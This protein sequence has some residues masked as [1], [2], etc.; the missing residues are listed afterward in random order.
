VGTPAARNVGAARLGFSCSP[1]RFRLEALPSQDWQDTMPE[2][3][4]RA[5]PPTLTDR[6]L[7]Q[8]H[9]ARRPIGRRPRRGR[10]SAALARTPEQ[11]QEARSLRRVFL[12]LGDAYRQYRRRTEA[13]VSA[14]VRDAAT[15]FRKEPSVTSLVSVAAHLD[16]LKILTW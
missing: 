10:S 4:P 6:V 11:L 3:S 5:V 7:A 9:E 1:H 15:R 16:E 14:A 13:P 2:P 8:I 12:D